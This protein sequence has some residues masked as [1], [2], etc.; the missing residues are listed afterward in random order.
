MNEGCLCVFVDDLRASH[1]CPLW[2]DKDSC[3]CSQGRLN[4][5]W[6]FPDV[7]VDRRIQSKVSSCRFFF[8][9]NFCR[10]FFYNILITSS[11][12]KQQNSDIAIRLSREEKRVC[13]NIF[14]H[15]FFVCFVFVDSLTMGR[16]IKYFLIH[17]YIWPLVLTFVDN[18]KKVAIAK[19][20]DIIWKF[21]R[22]FKSLGF[23]R[24][25]A[26]SSHPAGFQIKSCEL[27]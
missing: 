10:K 11:K 4:K 5:C 20:D 26:L 1:L 18:T 8:T 23:I 6:V 15:Q 14:F 24:W 16:S 22:A 27:C 25:R 9:R 13:H 17:N 7:V 12:L 3:L 19:G 2:F 21:W